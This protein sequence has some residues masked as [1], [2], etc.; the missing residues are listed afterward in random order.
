MEKVKRD[1]EIEMEFEKERI[2]A[3]EKERREQE[4]L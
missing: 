2:E 4:R 1:F 3:I